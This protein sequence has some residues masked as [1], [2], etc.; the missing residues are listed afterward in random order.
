MRPTSHRRLGLV[1]LVLALLSGCRG[2]SPPDPSPQASGTTYYRPSRDLGP[3]F[4]TV[5]LAGIFADSKTFVD[6][7]PLVPPETVAV[8]YLLRRDA[9]GFDLERFVETH[10]APPEPALEPPGLGNGVAMEDH[11]RSLW[12]LLTRRADDA[13]ARSSLLPLPEPYVVPGGRFREIYYW[14]SFFTMLGLV[15]AGRLDLVESMVD[16]FAHLIRS[17][18]FIPNGNRTYYLTRSQ[19]PF[20]SQMVMLL[21]AQTDTAEVAARY[22]DVLEREHAFW[23]DGA[24]AVGDGADAARHV[25][26]LPDGTIMNR[27]WDRGQTPRPESYREDYELAQ[28]L[29][30]GERARLWRDLRSAAES[31]WD[32]SSRWQ[33][34]PGELA[35]TRTTDIIPVDLNALL[36]A[37]ERALADLHAALGRETEAAR[38]GTLAA[39]RAAA[40]RQ[41]HWDDERGAFLDFHAPAGV[42]TGVLSLATVYPLY[43]GIATDAQAEQ[44]ARIVGDSLLGG[45]GFVTTTRTTGEQWDAPNGWAP[46]QWLA[47]RGLERYGHEELAHT[48]RDRWL[49]VNRAVYRNTGKM[50][51][52]YD[53]LDL[54]R[55]AGGGEYPTQDGFGWTNGVALAFMGRTGEDAVAPR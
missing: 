11:L 30:A 10:F 17:V 32:F 52:K 33:R 15:E 20:F 37:H 8:R 18:G 50:M 24:D 43:F 40:I 23:M 22:I 45:G 28:G 7:R 39:E 46:L 48:G 36:Y 53:V 31:G 51:E 27:Y 47:V 13:D 35:T 2:G 12:P 54:T 34:V 9:P 38:Y 14:D 5:Q 4:E 55:T 44:V 19:P 16:N 6:A 21:A 3:L 25:V 1:V 49:E 42:R 41:L 26:G 29:P